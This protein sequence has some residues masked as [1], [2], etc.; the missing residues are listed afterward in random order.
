MSAEPPSSPVVGAG[1]GWSRRRVLLGAAIALVSVLIVVVVVLLVRGPGEPDGPRAGAAA[2]EQELARLRAEAAAA[3]ENFWAR[4]ERASETNDVSLLDGIYAPGNDRIEEGQKRVVR[5][6]IA[7]HE[8]ETADIRVSN[9][10][11][12]EVDR[13]RARVLVDRTVSGGV[14]KDSRTGKVKYRSRNR[15]TREFSMVLVRVDG[16]WLVQGLDSVVKK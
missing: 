11:V 8:V 5:Q 10:R 3:A 14:I 13:M 4:V 12:L 2:E 16:R 6:Q 15:L 9:V 7:R 1:S